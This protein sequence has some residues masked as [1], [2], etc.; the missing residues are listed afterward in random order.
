MKKKLAASI[1][2]AAMLCTVPAFAFT[3]IG[4]H[5][6]R[7]YINYARESKLVNGYTDGSYG[8]E[9]RVTRAEF[10]T[11]ITNYKQGNKSDAA[12]PDV[13]RNDWYNGYVGYVTSNRIMNGYPDGTFRPNHFISRAEVAATILSMEYPGETAASAGFSDA[14]PDWAAN[15]IYVTAKHG[16][17]SGDTQKRFRPNDL[18]TRAE[19]ATILSKMKGFVPKE[20]PK[21]V[22]TFALLER[23]RQADRAAEQYALDN[24]QSGSTAYSIQYQYQLIDHLDVLH[25]DLITHLNANYG[26]GISSDYYLSYEQ[27][28]DAYLERYFAS[29]TH[30][31]MR[32]AERVDYTLNKMEEL[33]YPY[34]KV[35][36]LVRY[37]KSLLQ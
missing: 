25:K 27:E 36:G 32:L 29:E 24:T 5:W 10:A 16:I 8:P 30:P 23:I 6:A 1:L 17:F 11:M 35:S 2:T 19:A 28:R 13:S 18:L 15:A 9:G 4:G 37:H 22:Q 26:A 31:M 7:Q 3:D 20:E 21:P 33:E 12:F 14:L 34:L